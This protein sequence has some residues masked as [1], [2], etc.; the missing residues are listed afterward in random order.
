MGQQRN[1]SRGRKSIGALTKRIERKRKSWSFEQLEQRLVFSTTPL[2]Y[3][4]SSD[5]AQGA[6][7]TLADELR[8]AQ[9]AA[10]NGTATNF[11]PMSLPNDPLF[12]SQWHILNTGQ[13][14]GNPDLQ[15]LFGVAGQDA[16]VI[17]AWN[18]VD[19]QGRPI[20]GTGVTVAVIDS[21]VQLFHPD[22]AANISPTLRFNAVD[23][24]NIVGP[25]LTY[26]QA[27]HGTA[28]SGII[29]AVG[30]NAEGG[31]G[32]APGATIVPIKADNG[33]GIS[34]LAVQNALL[35]A[36]EHNSVVRSA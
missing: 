36:L 12:P 16:N 3:S 23:G 19:S 6:A 24:T 20:D 29:A 22:L 21:G 35:Y 27:G 13:E 14:V 7:L 10:S 15:H 33:F 18:M 32:I 31:T 9:A 5:N 26:V 25:N 2:S 34:D 30:N 11:A 4:F 8:W 28:V 1:A 17:P